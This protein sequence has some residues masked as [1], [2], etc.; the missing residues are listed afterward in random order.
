MTPRG[1]SLEKKFTRLIEGII[2]LIADYWIQ[3][4]FLEG[5]KDL[6]PWSFIFVLAA[7]GIFLL[8]DGFLQ[9]FGTSLREVVS[10]L[11][12]YASHH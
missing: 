7:L 8:V 2:V 4:A 6:L 1:K 10:M 9:L 11:Y 3:D 5:V 12:A